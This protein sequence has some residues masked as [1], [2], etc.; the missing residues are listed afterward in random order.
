MAC[1]TDEYPRFP[2]FLCRHACE[3]CLKVD[4]KNRNRASQIQKFQR[5]QP[6]LPFVVEENC[7]SMKDIWT[8]ITANVSVRLEAAPKV[9]NFYENRY[10]NSDCK[11]EDM[12]TTRAPESQKNQDQ[13]SNK[14]EKAEP[15]IQP[16]DDIKI[17]ISGFKEVTFSFFTLFYFFL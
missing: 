3:Y 2:N 8:K 9:S 5:L 15:M 6:Y 10:K 7:A 4:R 16:S 17:Q 1:S 14:G 12:L 11:T 13:I